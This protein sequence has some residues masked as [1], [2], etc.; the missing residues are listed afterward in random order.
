MMVFFCGAFG[1]CASTPTEETEKFKE[2]VDKQETEADKRLPDEQGELVC[3]LSVSVEA[4]L[5]DDFGF[6]KIRIDESDPANYQWHCVFPSPAHWI[7][8]LSLNRLAFFFE[9][10]FIHTEIVLIDRDNPSFKYDANHPDYKSMFREIRLTDT[11][12]IVPTPLNMD[13]TFYIEN[14][15]HGDYILEIYY[16]RIINDL[17]AGEP[18]EDLICRSGLSP[19]ANCQS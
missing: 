5:I 14:V 3:D 16:G 15:V 9:D 8:S 4:D 7:G 12:G 2:E 13:Q 18:I 11:T 1:I 19:K 6:L 17:N 10:E